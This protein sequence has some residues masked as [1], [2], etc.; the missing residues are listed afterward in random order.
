MKI[1]KIKKLL[2]A[3][4]ECVLRNNRC[5]HN[6]AVCD[7]VQEDHDL[8]EM[9]DFFLSMLELGWANTRF[10]TAET[11]EETIPLITDTGKLCCDACGRELN[12]HDWFCPGCGRWINWEK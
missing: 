11:R 4:R 8:V 10:E 7:L 12:V 2:Q 9:Y 6:C 3:E 1:D 5:D